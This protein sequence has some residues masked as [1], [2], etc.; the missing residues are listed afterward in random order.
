MPNTEPRQFRTTLYP[1]EPMH[2]FHW[3]QY[4]VILLTALV[5]TVYVVR[6]LP[7][8][9]LV[10]YVYSHHDN[11]TLPNL[12]YFV[13][14][15][16]K[17]GVFYIIIQGTVTYS[18]PTLPSNAHYI[19]HDNSCYDWGTLGW[20]LLH[21]GHIL[22]DDYTY[23]VFINSSV[24]GPF[25]PAYIKGFDWIFM[26]TS[27]ITNVVKIVGPTISCESTGQSLGIYKHNPHVQSYAIATDKTGLGI[28]L[29]A[30]AFTCRNDRWRTIYFSELGSSAAVLQ[31]GFNIA[32]FVLRYQ[33]VDWR[34]ESTWHCNAGTSP[35]NK[36]SFDGSTLQPL[37]CIFVKVKDTLV[38]AR[39]DSAVQGIQYDNWKHNSS[40]ISNKLFGMKAEKVL[41]LLNIGPACFDSSYYKTMNNEMGHNL[42]AIHMQAWD[43]F[44]NFGQFEGRVF[45]F[46]CVE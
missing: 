42:D 25:L 12:H 29:S 18:M 24:R 38:E 4:A 26:F 34:N 14:E 6:V 36:D 44:V 9:T 41:R 30:G 20:F 21:S 27:M 22:L 40:I 1:S 37:D 3:L 8:R 35:L 39:V 10:V 33:G 19:Y 7:N 17:T 28:M 15:I 46:R 13:K 5:Y 31:A 32:S 23:F 43:H 2:A 16:S 11:S 45:R